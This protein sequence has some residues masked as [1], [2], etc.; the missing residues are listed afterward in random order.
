MKLLF[1]LILNVF[2]LLIVAYIIP[3]FEFD[4]LWA[5]VV[6]AVVMGAVN[7]F[8]RPILQILFIPLTIVTLGVTAFL[9]NVVLL[10]GVSFIVPGFDI[11]SFMTAV[12]ASI[13]LTLIGLFLNKLGNDKKR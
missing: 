12:W 6:A 10:W 5:T 13:A 4:G 9:I 2:T 7:T 1:K 8:I 11:S 3:G